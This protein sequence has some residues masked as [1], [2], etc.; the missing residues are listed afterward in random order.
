MMFVMVQGLIRRF[1]AE[2]NKFWV[3][4]MH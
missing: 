1:S 3:F 4:S 2:S